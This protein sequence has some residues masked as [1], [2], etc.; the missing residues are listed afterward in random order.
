MINIIAIVFDPIL[1]QVDDEKIGG[2]NVETGAPLTVEIDETKM[3]KVKYGR[4]HPVRGVWVVVA[5]CREVCLLCISIL[6]K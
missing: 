4:G 2:I 1:L 6:Y 5:V 3:G